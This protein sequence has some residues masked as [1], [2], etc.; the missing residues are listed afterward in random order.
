MAARRG[1]FEQL[2]Y[3]SWC[4]GAS[5]IEIRRHADVVEHVGLAG[6][7]P[8]GGKCRAVAQRWRC[9]RL[10]RGAPGQQD[11]QQDRSHFRAS[12]TF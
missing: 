12:L 8:Q 11:E 4:R 5:R 9:R 1:Q 6:T 10:G 2:R 3:R 7:R